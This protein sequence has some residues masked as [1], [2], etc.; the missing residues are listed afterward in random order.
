MQRTYIVVYN[1]ETMMYRIAY[2]DYTDQRDLYFDDTGIPPFVDAD[3]AARVAEALN[4][5]QPTTH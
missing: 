5:A 1:S 2:R 3:A 4:Q